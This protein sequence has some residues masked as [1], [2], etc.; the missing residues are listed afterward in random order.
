MISC[1]ALHGKR[2]NASCAKIILFSLKK[3]RCAKKNFL[4]ILS[5]CLGIDL[6]MKEFKW[7]IFTIK[8]RRF[9]DEN[10]VY[11]AFKFVLNKNQSTTSVP[12][13]TMRTASLGFEP[14]TFRFLLQ[15]LNPLGHSPQQFPSEFP[16]IQYLLDLTYES[17]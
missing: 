7:K 8:F 14:G 15:C 1:L 6:F 2:F 16:F 12:R 17:R 9:H 11:L 5:N 4:F 10:I 3:S 13:P